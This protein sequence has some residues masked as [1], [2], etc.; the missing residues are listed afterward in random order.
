MYDTFS[1]VAYHALASRASLAPHPHR[2]GIAA[3][4]YHASGKGWSEGALTETAVRSVSVR[5]GLAGDS[6]KMSFVFGLMCA[7][8]GVGLGVGLGLGLGLGWG[9]GWA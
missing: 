5:V 2:P 7:W 8:S 9:W 1:H 3:V 6:E 4:A